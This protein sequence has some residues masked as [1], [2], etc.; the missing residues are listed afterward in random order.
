M[1][2]EVVSTLRVL[3][4]SAAVYGAHAVFVPAPAHATVTWEQDITLPGYVGGPGCAKQI[5]VGPNGVPWVIGCGANGVDVEVYWLKFTSCGS[6]CFGGT[7][8]WQD[9]R[10]AAVQISGGLQNDAFAVTANGHIWVNSSLLPDQQG[11][12]NWI[13]DTVS[14]MNPNFQAG[15]L[16]EVV[17]D[18]LPSGHFEMW[19]LG[20]PAAPN[21]SVWQNIDDDNA[22]WTHIDAQDNFTA[23]KV[24]IFNGTVFGQ[25][26]SE[27]VAINTSGNV[28]VFNPSTGRF[29]QIA[30]GSVTDITDH[31]CLAG[32]DVWEYADLANTWSVVGSTTTS[33]GTTIQQITAAPTGTNRPMWG[34]DGSGQ[35]FYNAGSPPP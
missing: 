18:V 26:Y 9:T 23:S 33:K 17:W 25:V 8:Q 27:V 32:G 11:P 5:A 16:S 21:N 14:V 24:V 6:G 15:R 7:Y 29:G 2:T 19:G 28:F 35:I 20:Y 4:L 10:F 22:V 1:R 31:F 30:G 34:I 3:A 13:D 12:G